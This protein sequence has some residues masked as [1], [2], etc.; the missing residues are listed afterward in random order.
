MNVE[1]N[2]NEWKLKIVKICIFVSTQIY[3]SH[4]LKNPFN[5]INTTNMELTFKKF[6]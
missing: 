4:D 1:N 5:G 6:M 2:T 3:F